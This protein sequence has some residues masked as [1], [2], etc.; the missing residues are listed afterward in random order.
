LAASSP[1]AHG[2]RFIINDGWTSWRDFLNPIVG[3][4][5]T[6]IHSYAPGELAQKNAQSRRG[7]LKRAFRAAISNSEVRRE[8]KQTMLGSLASRLISGTRLVPR[9]AT[10]L[11]VSPAISHAPPE[12]V[13]DLFGAYK[14]R[15]LSEKARSVLGWMPQVPLQEGQRLSVAYL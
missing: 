10:D 4:W 15:F 8:L 11:E 6:K 2:Q 14:T 9:P 1:R 3:P 13:E 5:H 7:A 12:W